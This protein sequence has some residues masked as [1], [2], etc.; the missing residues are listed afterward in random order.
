[1]ARDVA[2]VPFHRVERDNELV[3]DAA[4]SLAFGQEV[5]HLL[6]AG[7]QRLHKARQAR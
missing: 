4:V 7:R 3:G 6:L 1:L 2:V 5:Q